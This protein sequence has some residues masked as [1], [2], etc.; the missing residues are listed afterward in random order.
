MKYYITT[1]IDY[2]NAAPHIG[3]AY[4][5]VITDSYARFHRLMGDTVYFQTGVDEHGQKIQEAAVK[6]GKSP[7][8]YVDGMAVQ[9]QDFSKLLNIS[10]DY[11]VRTTNPEHKKICQQ[12]FE[13]VKKKGDIYLGTYKG[14]YCVP[15]ESFWTD[16]Q[17][18][19]GNCPSCKRPTKIVEEPSYF[20]KMGKYAQVVLDHIEKDGYVLPKSRAQEF[21]S[22]IKEGVNDLS[23]SRSSFDWGIP[24]PGDEQ[25]IMY[26]WFD[27]LLNYY[28]GSQFNNKKE[29]WPANC[30]V[31]GKDIAWFHTMIWLGILAAA[32]IPLPKHLLIHGFINDKN[33]EKMSKSKGN[34]INYKEIVD[35]YSVDGF[36]YYVLKFPLDTDPKFSEKELV[37]KYNHEL[38][39]DYGN[40][41]LRISKLAHTYYDGK[42][43]RSCAN[44]FAVEDKIEKIKEHMIAYEQNRA[45]DVAM[46]L[47]Y[48]ANRY[49]NEKEP[50][51]N[52]DDREDVLYACTEVIRIASILLRSFIPGSADK[53]LDFI[54]VVKGPASQSL[55]WG[56]GKFH[57]KQDEVL[58][59]RIDFVEQQEFPLDLRVAKVLSVQDHPEAD[60]LYVLSIDLGDEKRQLVAGMKAYYTKEELLGK[61]IIVVANMK[62]AKLRGIESQGMMLAA[63]MKEKT[64]EGEKEIVGIM[65][66]TAPIGTQVAPAA[67][68]I[69]SKKI[70]YKEFSLLTLETGKETLQVNGLSCVAHT[71][72]VVAE[73]VGS[74]CK[75]R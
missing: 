45:L 20:F 13:K 65:T 62:S 54:G 69:S 19:E 75:I 43:E 24:I 15:C 72:H 70:D 40:V 30:H 26:V 52:G 42:L 25:H 35:K 11:F 29:F 59:P 51:K 36:R 60:K 73:R 58:F 16:L 3:H 1:A 56:V 8:E 28:T 41:L 50:W 37:E 53:A 49:L 10:Y 64:A 48:D 61:N 5:K 68:A 32:D 7:Q 34:A 47:V 33:G 44:P 74:G 23:V 46:T 2:P 18:V 9:Y 66:T 4:E 22:R 71:H 57:F 14:H 27:A 63:E 21:I 12:I 31:I 6:Q 67:H 39:N 17:L 55:E 38:G